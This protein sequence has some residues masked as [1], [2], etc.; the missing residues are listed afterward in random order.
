MKSQ[1][2]AELPRCVECGA[3]LP[4]G[5]KDRKFCSVSCKNRHHNREARKWRG[6]YART[7]GILQRNHEIL[8]R[9]IQMGVRAISKAELV[10]MGY[11]IDFMTSCRRLRSR[12]VCHCFDIVFCETE[13]RLTG[14][15]METAP[16][17]PEAGE[18]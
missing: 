13:N 4:Y 5:R 18:E 17:L 16:W 14:L 11:Q 6:R 8:R 15:D 3:I 7:I 9:L 10:Q 1:S 2:D 12:T